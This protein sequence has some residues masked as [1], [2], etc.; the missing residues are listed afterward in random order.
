[1]KKRDL[2]LIVF[3]DFELMDLVYM[4]RIGIVDYCLFNE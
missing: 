1:M 2:V 4:G 3:F